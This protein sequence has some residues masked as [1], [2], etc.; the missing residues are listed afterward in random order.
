MNHS[1]IHHEITDR[2]DSTKLSTAPWTQ[3]KPSHEQRTMPC[4]RSH[5]FAFVRNHP[6]RPLYKNHRPAPSCPSPP[7]P[8]QAPQTFE[9]PVI[10][11]C[12]R[13]QYSYECGC[14]DIRTSP[15]RNARLGIKCV[16]H[17]FAAEGSPIRQCESC[18]AQGVAER[19][20][21]QAKRPRS[22]RRT[23]SRKSG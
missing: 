9:P 5:H 2:G 14:V 11:M 18:I 7:P 4:P 15:C 3:A 21:E 19:L 16:Q 12:T 17:D 8:T 22:L 13:T 20:N 23:F 6:L 1:L 10:V